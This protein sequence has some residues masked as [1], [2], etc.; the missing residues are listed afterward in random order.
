MKERRMRNAKG[1]GGGSLADLL[2]SGRLEAFLSF[3]GDWPAEFVVKPERLDAG[4]E[5]DTAK[6]DSDP[7]DAMSS[8]AKASAVPDQGLLSLREQI[9]A[10][11]AAQCIAAEPDEVIVTATPQAAIALIVRALLQPGDTV[12]VG[13]RTHPGSLAVFRQAKLRVVPVAFDDEGMDAADLE[14]L[15][16]RHQ[17]KL[18]YTMPTIGVPDATIWSEERRLALLACSRRYGM[19]VVED[20]PYGW[21]RFEGAFGNATTSTV[22]PSPAPSAVQPPAAQLSTS[23]PSAWHSPVPALFELDRRNGGGGVLYASTFAAML[24]PQASAGWIASSRADVMARLAN[25]KPAGRAEPAEQQAQRKLE[26][27]LRHCG[28]ERHAHTVRMSMAS[29][30]H[31]MQ[32]LLSR[33][34]LSGVAWHEPPGGMFLWVELPLGLDAEALLRCAAAKRVTFDIGAPF[35]AGHPERNRIRLNVANLPEARMAEGVARFAEAV[36]EFLGRSST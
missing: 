27:L 7:E 23:Q 29:R 11:M 6:D 31:R 24:G 3:A 2:H 33:Q 18:V 19:L 34:G 35:Y 8:A 30:M 12:L 21:L 26:R 25:A 13:E 17:P 28:L 10:H 4:I 16:E 14:R 5:P 20:D 36:N 15:A 9:C 32:D 1:P 22:P